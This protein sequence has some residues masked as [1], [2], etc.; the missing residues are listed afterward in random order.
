M[1]LTS[2]H[3][4]YKRL[5]IKNEIFSASFR[6]ISEMGELTKLRNQVQANFRNATKIQNDLDESHIQ[7]CFK[8]EL[9]WKNRGTIKTPWQD[10]AN[11][12]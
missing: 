5:L 11:V 10:H 12:F 3:Y 7:S 4:L 1:L 2:S 6:V 8:Y 9:F